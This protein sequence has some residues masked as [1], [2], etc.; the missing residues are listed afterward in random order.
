V[1]VE[2]NGPGIAQEEREKVFERFYRISDRGVAGSGLGLA[3]VREIAKIHSAEV[4][5]D[6]GPGGV[7][8]SIV[9]DFPFIAA[10][11]E[12]TATV[13]AQLLSKLSFTNDAH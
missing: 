12:A 2:D 1:I 7:G 11:S 5:L 13:G 10:T 4:H 9:I 3:I 6:D 8:T